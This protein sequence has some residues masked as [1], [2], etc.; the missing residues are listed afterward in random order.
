MA[1]DN[2]QGLLLQAAREAVNE[3][4]VRCS[5][6]AN[7]QAPGKGPGP[8]AAPP[9]CCCATPPLVRRRG[10]RDTLLSTALAGLQAG[11]VTPSVADI[12]HLEKLFDRLPGAGKGAVAL[13]DVKVLLD[14]E[15]L[16]VS[17]LPGLVL[18]GWVLGRGVIAGCL[19]RPNPFWSHTLY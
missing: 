6:A 9:V 12:L 2:Q 14:A 3:F 18:P 17:M 1:A 19:S 15:V 8:A 13:K 10:R 16:A 4:Q 11:R 5:A 7:R